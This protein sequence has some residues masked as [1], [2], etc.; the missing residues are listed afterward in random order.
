MYVLPA[1]S[2]FPAIELLR[3]RTACDGNGLSGSDRVSST[4]LARITRLCAAFSAY[5]RCSVA[6]S[7]LLEITIASLD[8]P[9]AIPPAVHGW[10]DSQLKW[11]KLK[12]DLPK[13][14][15]EQA[16]QS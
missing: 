14:R 7:H 16:A 13:F 1:S 12:D 5:V 11:L 9:D 8:S 10:T 15:E 2:F 6:G 4:S 3:V